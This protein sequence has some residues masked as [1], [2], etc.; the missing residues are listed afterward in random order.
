MPEKHITKPFTVVSPV[1]VSSIMKD[2][3]VQQLLAKT[4]SA[5]LVICY[6][7]FPTVVKAD[8]CFHFWQGSFDRSLTNRGRLYQNC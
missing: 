3:T 4:R 1:Y 8:I 6:V 5:T 2:S 7:A